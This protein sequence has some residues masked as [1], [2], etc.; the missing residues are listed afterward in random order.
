METW[1]ITNGTLYEANTQ[2]IASVG[3]NPSEPD[4]PGVAGIPGFTNPWSVVTTAAWAAATDY[5]TGDIVSFSGTYYVSTGAHTSHADN[6]PT[7]PLVPAVPDT[8]A[9]DSPWVGV[10]DKQRLG[11]WHGLYCPGRS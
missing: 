6:D 10:H 8:P 4:T 1:L 11:R 7:H 9:F 5:A 3:N 2:H